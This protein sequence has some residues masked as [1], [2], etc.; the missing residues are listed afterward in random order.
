MHALEHDGK[1]SFAQAGAHKMTEHHAGQ[2]A[3]PG[4]I[5]LAEEQLLNCPALP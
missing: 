1:G 4:V 2:T 3:T 5:W